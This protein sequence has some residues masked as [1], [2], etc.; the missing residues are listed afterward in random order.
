MEPIPQI[1]I[2]E[3]STEESIL[4]GQGI[5][6]CINEIGLIVITITERAVTGLAVVLSLTL[7]G[8]IVA[9]VTVTI[10]IMKRKRI[11]QNTDDE[12]NG[13]HTTLLL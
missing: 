13:I 5:Y 7:A 8:V 12:S 6:V 9:I 3:D 4:G 11:S 1:T 2:G 10:F